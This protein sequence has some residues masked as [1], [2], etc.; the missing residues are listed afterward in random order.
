MKM[1]TIIFAL[2]L[3]LMSPA[4]LALVWQDPYWLP[5]GT[6]DP[7]TVALGSSV[8]AASGG[9]S[10]L[11][12]AV[13]YRVE[14]RRN[15]GELISVLDEKDVD[16]STY[17][18]FE[19]VEITQS[20]YSVP[21]SYFVRFTV[22]DSVETRNRQLRLVI[23]EEA[24]NPPVLAFIP[25]KT[26]YENQLLQFSIS[27]SDPDGD[28][29][30]FSAANLP[31]GA[32][33]NTVT[34]TFTWTP[35]YD[36]EGVYNVIFI[37]TD[38]HGATDSQTVVITVLDVNR[39][40]ELSPIGYRGVREG[41]LLQFSLI[42]SDADADALT[43]SVMGSLP[44]GATFNP[45]TRIFSWTPGYTQ[46]GTYYVTFRV[47][48][49]TCSDTEMIR[50]IV[51]DDSRPVVD[52]SATPEGGPE[53]VTVGF[54]CSVTGGDAPISYVIEFGDGT[55]VMNQTSANHTYTVEGVYV[56][57]CTVIDAD[58]DFASDYVGINVTVGNTC[59]VLD[60]LTDQSV[61]VGNELTFTVSAYDAE[62]DALVYSADAP[63]SVFID[64]VTGVFSW[65][66]SDFQ[67]GNHVA[68]FR[69]GDGTCGDSQTINILV[70]RGF[71][72]HAPDADFN[73]TPLVPAV[74]D[75]VTFTS[76][77]SD[78]DGDSLACA[79]D[80]DNDGYAD[81][82][83]CAAVWVFTA[84]GNHSV[85]LTISD[86]EL[87]DSIIHTITVIGQL[88][89]TNI[90]CL[91]PVIESTYNQST[92]QSCA[93]D[94]ESNGVPV[95]GANV[96]LHYMDGTVIR[97]CV[98]DS[99]TGA[100]T[101]TFTPGAPGNYTV[102][103]TAEKA[104]WVPD[105]DT[106]PT[107]DFVVLAQRYYVSN[108]NV[109]NDPAFL[110]WDLD[111][112]RGEDMYVSFMVVDGSGNPID[113]MVTSV[114]LV[115]PPGGIAWF[116]EFPYATPEAGTYYYNLRIP[117]IHDFLGN[118]QVF[119][120]AF[121]FTDGSG[122]EM[123]V[124]V[125]IRNNPPVIN[126]TVADEFDGVFNATTVINMTP[127]ESDVEDSGTALRW[128]VLG[129]DSSIALVS[130]DPY[131]QLTITPVSQGYDVITLVLTDLDGDIDTIDVPVN[132]GAV[133]QPACSDGLDN[134][135]DGLIDLAD[136]G[137]I[138][139]ADDDEAN[140]VVTQCSDGLDND[141][142]GLIDLAD[143]G[144]EN[145]TDDDETDT[146]TPP[147]CNDGLDNDGDGFVDLADIGCENIADDDET[148]P[149]VMPECYDGLDNDGDGLFDLADPGCSGVGDDDESDPAIVHQ[150]NDG[151]D[152]DGDGL[153]DYPADPGCSGSDD[154]NELDSFVPQCSDGLDNDGD[155]LFDMADP[156]CLNIMDD[157][158][159][160]A[161]TVYQCNDGADNDGDGLVDMADSG[162]D[163]LVDD[164]EANPLVPQCSDGLDNDGDGLV[165]LAD[166]DCR[167][168]SDDNE[169]YV[170]QCA[171]GIDND[172]D[173][174]IDW[175]A[176]LHCYSSSDPYEGEMFIAQDLRVFSD[177][178][179][180]LITRIDIYGHDIDREVVAPGEYFR[181]SVGL[182]NNLDY[183]LK[184]IK[185]E[186]SI[187]ELGARDTDVLRSLDKDDSA[188]VV[189]NMD[190]PEDAA[191][192]LY[193]VRIVA[194]NNDIRRVKYRTI[195]VA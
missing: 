133:S 69:V 67:V 9:F 110:N 50:I 2:L 62:G 138:D 55:Y 38:E 161:V 13:H 120:F 78:P 149:V 153:V 44:P 167:N 126:D 170:A 35:N 115:S 30:S 26:I 64:P 129:V 72:N 192:G 146:V 177:M 130:V 49:G 97:N 187:Y 108:L 123:V 19:S 74:G 169:A 75:N 5:V 102:Y 124:E 34:R 70:T 111:F 104:G 163:S 37:V 21:G 151:A 171:D 103:A 94:V 178:D 15:T 81:S 162:C 142:D 93:V 172:L 39:C 175:P 106:V 7:N 60:P 179:D 188:T 112:F 158:E 52:L 40:P 101:V 166:P 185:V 87:S 24:N 96:V 76:N 27:G 148:N 73:W 183:K 157:D 86:G 29:I 105:L 152:N 51:T 194:S 156:G 4:A 83:D 137:C 63:Y 190:I 82:T 173:G 136:P 61:Q 8:T 92:W 46:A 20:D 181:F 43:Y 42:A 118:S 84:P 116:V 11:D 57:S 1:R 53:G 79:W 193:D 91:S 168:A 95:G 59:P 36:Q 71:E 180:L 122:A 85:T 176:D 65:T 41:D 66:P 143:L 154:D 25:D 195:I 128:S 135:A 23:T 14:L 98:T 147:A 10:S 160:N 132:T 17:T 47:S 18:G 165:D 150:C 119:T 164:D 28:S 77:S 32:T 155:G 56:A 88:N 22:S 141:A 58:G 184:D 117:A 191:P 139:S 145:A 3:V 100:C 33:F 54:V 31:S 140:A 125:V 89:V 80:F 144:C 99:I 113:G 114:A 68:T 109:Y 186:A 6:S 182:Q 174:R 121:N 48:D 16:I 131:D 90:E 12:L 189:F 45:L 134:D 127:Y 107:E 159:F